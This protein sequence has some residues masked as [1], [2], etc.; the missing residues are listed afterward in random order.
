MT[1]ET[2]DQTPIWCGIHYLLYLR[3]AGAEEDCARFSLFQTEYSPA[4][5]GHAGYLYVDRGCFASAPANGVYTDNPDMAEWM[6]DRMYRD[7]DNPLAEC[8]DRI[9]TARFG[10]SGDM[11][12]RLRYTMDTAECQIEAAWA[13]LEPPFVHHGIAGASSLY[14]YCLFVVANRA[15]L[16][17]DGEAVP[18]TLYA[19]QDWIPLVGRPLSSCLL[20]DEIWATV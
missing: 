13:G 17:V 18:G 19:R 3:L 16:V 4:G 20:A 14:T 7:S 15:S 10:R 8:G 2:S 1:R 12:R 6:Y 9:V 5:G 11:R